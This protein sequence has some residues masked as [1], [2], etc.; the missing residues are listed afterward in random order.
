MKKVAIFSLGGTGDIILGCQI[1]HHIQKRTYGNVELICLARDET[2]EPIKLLFGDQIEIKQHELK[3]KWG[4]NYQLITNPLILKEEKEKYSEIVV[5]APDLLFRARE[6]SFDFLKYNCSLQSVVQTRLL[7]NKYRPEKIVYC[8][9]ANT[10]TKDYACK[11]TK[12]LIELMAQQLPDYNFY[13][14][15][16]LKWNNEDIIGADKNIELKNLPPNVLVDF[17]PSWERALSFMSKSVYSITLDSAPFHLSYQFGLERLC[18]DPHFGFKGNNHLWISR[19]RNNGFHDSV[20]INSSPEAIAQLVI[21]NIRT[22]QTTLLTKY[23]VL[24]NLDANW[25][26]QLGFKF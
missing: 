6:Y 23:F 18:L 8:A 10:T 5:C 2:F 12:Q 16:L 24:N 19:W 1:A 20:D 11:H 14:P 13:V 21:T 3:E 17:N 22:P 15:V 25:E 4:E 7:I 9:F 26:Q